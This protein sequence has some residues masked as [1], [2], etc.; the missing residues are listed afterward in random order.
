MLEALC[1]PFDKVYGGSLLGEV[2]SA[3]ALTWLKLI[4]GHGEG[5]WEK[6][7]QYLKPDEGFENTI[8][9]LCN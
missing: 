3:L 4:V 8:A 2:L 6:K 5:V 7:N 1:F 9:N